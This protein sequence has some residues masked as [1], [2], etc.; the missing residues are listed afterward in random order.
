MR[1]FVKT[2]AFASAAFGFLAAAAP[3]SALTIV[4]VS[5]PSTN[6]TWNTSCTVL[7]TDSVG[8][9]T[10]PGDNGAGRLQSRTYPG[11]PPA[12]AA[13]LMAYVYRV[14]LTSVT[15]LTAVNCV[16]GLVIDF[17]AV[18]PLKYTAKGDADVFVVTSGGLGSVGVA[19]AT[20]SGTAIKFTFTAPVCPGATTYFFGLGSKATTPVA[21]T[22]QLIWSLGGTGTTADRVP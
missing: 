14:D 9:F 22:A 1:A 5:A 8:N 10:P 16:S 4:D 15:G 6:C 12:P 20:Q 2:I 18:V 11:T 7:V 17:G 21:G 19:S 13:G 3:A